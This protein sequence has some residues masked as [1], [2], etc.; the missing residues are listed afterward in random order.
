M[1]DFH[2]FE[3]LCAMRLWHF[4]S[5]RQNLC[6][7]CNF[8]W[9]TCRF[10][11]SRIRSQ[12]TDSDTATDTE[13]Q[14]ADWKTTCRPKEQRDKERITKQR[15][16]TKQT[17]RQVVCLAFFSWLSLSSWWK[18][19]CCIINTSAGPGESWQTTRVAAICKLCLPLLSLILS[20]SIAS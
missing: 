9:I 6:K 20:L 1:C 14:R 12:D 3:S 17:R 13:T 7:T 16:K 15:D 11:D 5:Q 4:Y 19:A 2:Y 10:A 18:N 8:Y